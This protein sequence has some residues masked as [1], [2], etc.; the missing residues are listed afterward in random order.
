MR[1]TRAILGCMTL[2]LVA[3]AD[4]TH[5]AEVA[6]LGPEAPGVSPGPTHRPGQP[7]LTCHGGE[8][9][10]GMTFVTAG[11]I[12]LNQYAVGTTVYAPV[13]GGS[14]HL[15][16]ATGSTYNATTN[17]VGNFYVTTDQWNP[18]FPLGAQS[19]DA[20][21]PANGCIPASLASVETAYAGQINVAG[22]VEGG[23]EPSPTP[24]MI[25]STSFAIDRGGIYASCSYCHFDPPGP[26]SAGHVYLQ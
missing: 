26:R 20:G 12:Y 14:V 19:Q 16:D 25:G 10:G 18:T 15:V 11:T 7:C 2:A 23:C 22:P 17:S 5:S 3:C 24:M 21:E 9:P 8:G 6:A 4:P 13:V 1:A